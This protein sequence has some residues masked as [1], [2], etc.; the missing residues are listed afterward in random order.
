[1]PESDY[2]LIQACRRGDV[3]AWEQVLEKYERLVFSIALKYGLSTEDSAD[4]TQLTFTILM[5][6]LDQ[7]RGDT[8]LGAWLAT[9]AKRHAWRSLARRRREPVGQEKDVAEQEWL[10]GRSTDPYEDWERVEWLRSGLEQLDDRCREIISLLYFEPERPS[11][12]QLAARLEVPVGSIGPTRAR[13]LE[14][15]KGLLA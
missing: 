6:S 13:C 11:Y 3:L 8:R 14:R 4:I 12:A 15:L 5:Q 7:L 2:D 9:V 1:M 10:S